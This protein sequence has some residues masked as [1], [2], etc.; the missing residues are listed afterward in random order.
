[1]I[2][3][4]STACIGE[5]VILFVSE[6][7]IG[8]VLPSEACLVFLYAFEFVRDR[9]A[10]LHIERIRNRFR[11]VFRPHTNTARRFYKDTRG[12]AILQLPHA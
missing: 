10:K 6:P 11:R 4:A 7:F 1:M 9:E 5:S 12:R 2:A 8:F 3:T